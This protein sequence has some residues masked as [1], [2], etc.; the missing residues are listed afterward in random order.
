M[1]RLSIFHSVFFS[2][3]LRKEEVKKGR[4]YYRGN[5][6]NDPKEY[7]TAAQVVMRDK[8]HKICKKRRYFFFHG[9]FCK[10][11]GRQL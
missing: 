5:K 7:E 6:F 11:K 2:S 8:T 9:K 3:F 4:N 10:K 1:N